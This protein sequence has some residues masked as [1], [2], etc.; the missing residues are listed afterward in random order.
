MSCEGNANRIALLFETSC[1][2]SSVARKSTTG[3]LVSPV[4]GLYIA[5]RA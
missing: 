4:T 1:I 3:I 2:V 5:S